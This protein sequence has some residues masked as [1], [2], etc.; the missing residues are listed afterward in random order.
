MRITLKDYETG[1]IISTANLIDGD[2]YQLANRNES[3]FSEFTE[4]LYF[5]NNADAESGVIADDWS[6][7]YKTPVNPYMIWSLTK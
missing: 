1:E 7:D 3:F 2:V 5:I 4:A 6:D